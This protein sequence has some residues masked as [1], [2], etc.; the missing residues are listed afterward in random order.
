LI[1]ITGGS[2]LCRML[3]TISRPTRRG[4]T[5]VE[6]LVVIGIIALLISILLPALSKARESANRVKCASNLKQL[7]M[8]MVL[9]TNDNR[10]FLPFASRNVAPIYVEDFIYWQS[11]RIA[12]IEDSLARYLDFRRTN[13][14]VM[15][16]P[17]DEYQNRRQQNGAGFGPY[18]FSYAMNYMICGGNTSLDLNVYT[19]CKKLTQVT[20]TS[21]KIFMY[22]EDPYTIDDGN[23]VLYNT[24]FVN[25]L[26]LR[27]DPVLKRAVDNTNSG[28]LVPNP[29]GKGN[30]LFAD[31]HVDFVT[32]QY[33]HSPEHGVGAPR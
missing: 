16:C 7:G 11:S 19:L 32:R 28:N 24:S 1:L 8:A 18:P 2:T 21:D 23:G 14:A 31:S 30:V 20:Q 4:F 17:S 15:R 5:L 22:E 12:N 3:K 27:H 10:G 33:A 29:L 6:L 25:L 13:L 26:S 9:Y